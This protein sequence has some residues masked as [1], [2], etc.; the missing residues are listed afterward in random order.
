[1]SKLLES[2][3]PVVF[4]GNGVGDHLLNLPSLRALAKLF[5]NRLRLVCMPGA[6]ATYF[7]DIPFGDVLETE[8]NWTGNRHKFDAGALSMR[9]GPCR[10]FLSLV[11]WH[12]KSMDQLLGIVAP[13]HS[14]GFFAGFHDVLQPDYSKHS[15]DLAFELPRRLDPTLRLEAFA[16]PP[17][18]AARPARLALEIR[19]AV[20]PGMRVLAIHA[21]TN[22]EKMWPVKRW[23]TF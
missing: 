3:H 23:C 5:P 1:M 10:L 18:L 6:A 8:M 2:T 22:S 16:A 4:F 13:A 21:D 14:I 17:A 7:S 12:S 9:I 19:H 15:A 20:P 11:P